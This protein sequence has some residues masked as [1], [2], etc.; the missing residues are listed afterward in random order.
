[1]QPVNLLMSHINLESN[2]YHAPNALAAAQDTAQSQENV[3]E[4]I[5]AVQ[6][7]QAS[8]AAAKS[9]KIK[10]RKDDNDKQEK[11]EKKGFD[12]TC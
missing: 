1:M 6:K 8:E 5:K 3:K 7:V 10:R 4:G 12:F 2:V 9:Q 11:Q